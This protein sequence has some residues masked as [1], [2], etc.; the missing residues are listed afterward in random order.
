MTEEEK[1]EREEKS[2]ETYDKKGVNRLYSVAM[3]K[4]AELWQW[5]KKCRDVPNYFR[6]EPQS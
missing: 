3:F 5:F 1:S 2:I 6:A 4:H